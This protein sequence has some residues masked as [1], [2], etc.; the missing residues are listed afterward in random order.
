MNVVTGIADDVLR[1]LIQDV[2]QCL[3]KET[4]LIAELIRQ[5]EGEIQKYGEAAPTAGETSSNR[6]I[7]TGQR[8]Q[9]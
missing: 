1:F 4:E 3:D 7:V 2:Q 9:G 8:R 6:R 5:N